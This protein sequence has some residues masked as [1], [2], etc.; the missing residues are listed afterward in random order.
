MPIAL[1]ESLAAG[2][3]VVASDVDGVREV[4]SGGGGVM[5]PRR[6]P[7]QTAR[8]L[9]SLLYSPVA[10]SVAASRD[11]GADAHALM[12]SYDELLRTVLE[13]R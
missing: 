9:R 8:A 13:G 7:E 4:L 5:V 1:L 2:R 12:K 3:P 11:G 6:S 10:R